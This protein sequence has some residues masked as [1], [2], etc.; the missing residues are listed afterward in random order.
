MEVRLPHDQDTLV[1]NSHIGPSTPS[2]EAI[3]SQKTYTLSN[4]SHG[5]KMQIAHHIAVSAHC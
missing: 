2:T 3:Q 1:W 5:A 4:C